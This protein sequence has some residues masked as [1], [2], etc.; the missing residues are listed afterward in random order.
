MK[1]KNEKRLSTTR[2]IFEFFSN[3]CMGHSI[4]INNWLICLVYFE[5]TWNIFIR[6]IINI[7]WNFG[8]FFYTSNHAVN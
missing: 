6:H 1:E 8:S 7:S 3:I 2:N 5:Y 4:D